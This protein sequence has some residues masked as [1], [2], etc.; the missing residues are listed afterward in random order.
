MSG[1][2]ASRKRATRNMRFAS[3]ALLTGGSDKPYA[4]GL[5]TALA[6]QGLAVDFI[7]SD[8]LDCA[9]VHAISDLKF[10]D[11]R[12][13]QREDVPFLG[14]LKRVLLL[15]SVAKLCGSHRAAYPPHS[16]EQ[17]VRVL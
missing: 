11:L 10:L 13:D 7:A 9:E 14:K 1:V 12:G 8:E 2:N 5:A 15:R 16:L 3:V 17:Q 4:L 6:S